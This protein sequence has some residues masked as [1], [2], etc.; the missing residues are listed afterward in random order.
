M[1]T[2]HAAGLALVALTSAV[3]ADACARKSGPGS[4][5]P[6]PVGSTQS[7]IEGG[8]V[9]NDAANPVSSQF[10]LSTVNIATPAVKPDGTPG[11][12]RCTGEIVSPTQILTAAHCPLS[13]NTVIGLYSTT[14]GTGADPISPLSTSGATFAFPP[15]VCIQTTAG[16]P[17][18]GGLT[19]AE[20]NFYT[21]PAGTGCNETNGTFAD[22]A[23]IHVEHHDSQALRA[24]RRLAQGGRPLR[25]QPTTSFRHGRWAPA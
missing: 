14:P 13:S 9:I 23:L 19:C 11:R 24:E 15:G 5:P 6:D 20:S 1:P 25:G 10:P 22:L 12:A 4:P 2:T 18:A 3:F 16:I 7:Q 8:R 21:C 17:F